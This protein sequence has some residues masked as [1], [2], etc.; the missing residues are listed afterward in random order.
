MEIGYWP[1]PFLKEDFDQDLFVPSCCGTWK[2]V[3][4]RPFKE[5]SLQSEVISSQVALAEALKKVP[6]VLFT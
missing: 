2:E 6:G 1:G 4:L 5:G 3:S